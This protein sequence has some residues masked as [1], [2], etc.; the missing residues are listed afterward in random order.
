MRRQS[1][2]RGRDC[3]NGLSGCPNRVLR[4]QFTDGGVIPELTAEVVA[5]APEGAVSFGCASVVKTSTDV[6]PGCEGA[7]LG[8]GKFLGGGV[9]ADLTV[10]V[11]APAPECAILFGSTSAE[12]SGTNCVPS[13]FGADLG[14]GKF[15]GGGVVADLTVLV[16]APAPEGAVGFCCTRV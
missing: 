9:V 6:F 3:W 4:S 10:L 15:L 7:D 2:C 1:R 14:R 5:P 13:G 16:A 8:G 12:V 11:V